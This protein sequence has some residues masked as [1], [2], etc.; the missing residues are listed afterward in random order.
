MLKLVTDGKWPT[1]ATI[2]KRPSPSA[3]VVLVLLTAE[4]F[5]VGNGIG[6]GTELEH[7]I[8]GRLDAIGHDQRIAW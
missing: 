5:A 2:G 3:R 8:V 4:A 7:R 1:R 6:C